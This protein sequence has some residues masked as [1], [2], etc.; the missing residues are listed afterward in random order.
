MGV[1]VIIL[2][3]M[4]GAIAAIFIIV[5]GHNQDGICPASIKLPL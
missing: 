1:I 2:F 4:L 3:L 5:I